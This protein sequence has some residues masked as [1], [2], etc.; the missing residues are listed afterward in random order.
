MRETEL[1][2]GKNAIR[3]SMRPPPPVHHLLDPELVGRYWS[4]ES[5]P[6]KRNRFRTY[7]A[8]ASFAYSL[9]DETIRHLPT[10]STV[11]EVG[12][13]IGLLGHLISQHGHKVFLF[14]PEGADFGSMREHFEV[15]RDAWIGPP[16]DIEP[17]WN[18][19]DPQTPGLEPATL[20]L[21]FNVIEHVPDPAALVAQ[22]TGL[23]TPGGSG[24]FVCPNYWFPYEPHF[25][26]PTLLNKRLT[27]HILGSLIKPNGLIREP[28]TFWQDLSWPNPRSLHRELIHQ[29]VRHRFSREA[30]SAYLSRLGEPAFL[31]RKG[32]TMAALSKA[33]H[34]VGL[35]LK[36]V[37]TSLL[38]IIDLRTTG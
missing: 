18:V 1:K 9:L 26:M 37:P 3:Q 20:V 21:A 19:L 13:G 36:C 4:G 14:E 15:V 31:E 24:R 38:P 28:E 29:D 33:D 12:S 32:R 17:H 34:L 22:A 5:D 8:E 2:C 6:T 25:C 7:I 23:L 10:G 11:I 16:V 27:Q 30:A 35:A